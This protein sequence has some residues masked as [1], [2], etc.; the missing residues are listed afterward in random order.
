MRLPLGQDSAWVTERA[1]L[2]QLQPVGAAEVVRCTE[3]GEL[4]EGLVTNF[5]VVAGGWM[6]VQQ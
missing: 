4:L 5:F 3:E 6:C 1:P 2:E